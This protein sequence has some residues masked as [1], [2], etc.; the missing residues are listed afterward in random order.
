MIH[1]NKTRETNEGEIKEQDIPLYLE[2]QF[3]I[4]H[5]FLTV[6]L[7]QDIQVETRPEIEILLN[8]EETENI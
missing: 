3:Q 7:I 6:I 8:W 1:P 5:R 2:S 4:D